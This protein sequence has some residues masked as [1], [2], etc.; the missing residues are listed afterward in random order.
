[1]TKRSLGGMYK[2][3]DGG[4]MRLGCC[5]PDSTIAIFGDLCCDD[6][7]AF[8]VYLVVGDVVN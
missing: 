1:M 4:H 5:Y 6:I 3:I 7:R 2:D 8:D